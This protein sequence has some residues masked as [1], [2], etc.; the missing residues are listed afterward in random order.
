MGFDF[1]HRPSDSPLI[2]AIWR[3]CSDSAGAFDS[4]AA[5]YSGLVVMKH[6]GK[7]ILSV[8]GPETKMSVAEFPADAEWCGIIFKFGTY[9]PH[10]PPHMVID[11]R[12]IHLPEARRKTFWMHG[13][14]WEFPDFENVDTFLNRLMR[15]GLL[16]RDPIVNAAMQ[17]HLPDVT[18][19]SVQNHF[20]RATGLTHKLVYQIERS[21]RALALLQ[22]GFSILDTVDELGY[23]D[24]P[25][26]TRSLKR[27]MGQTP[28]QVMRV[29]TLK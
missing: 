24:Q 26:L 3:T 9:M 7:T 22:Q 21:Q 19:R 17:G 12:E 15:Q 10:L 27:F 5:I 16:V 11:R 28:A 20:L 2:Q 25:H 6:Q 1:E 18:L 23:A 29:L 13:S 4:T 14:T 8:R